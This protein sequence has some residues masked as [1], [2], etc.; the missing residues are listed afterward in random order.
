VWLFGLTR[1]PARYNKQKIWSR[2]E[3]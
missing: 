3:T 1:R 2:R